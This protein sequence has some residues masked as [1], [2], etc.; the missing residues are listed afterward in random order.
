MRGPDGID[1]AG[2]V[3][4]PEVLGAAIMAWAGLLG[5]EL[6]VRNMISVDHRY[7]DKGKWKEESFEGKP[8]EE[9]T[10]GTADE[11]RTAT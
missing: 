5:G 1:G 6:V 10:V 9:V 7:A 4:H 11:L 8:G 3:W 2:D